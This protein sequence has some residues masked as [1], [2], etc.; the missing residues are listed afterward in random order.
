MTKKKLKFSIY[1]SIV[2]NRIKSIRLLQNK[3]LEEWGKIFGASKGN[4]LLWE[5]GKTLPNKKRLEKIAELGNTTINKLL[6]GNCE[7]FLDLNFIYYHILYN[8]PVIED[9]FLLVDIAS[10]I[11][12]KA[13]EAGYTVDELEKLGIFYKDNFEIVKNELTNGDKPLHQRLYEIV[14]RYASIIAKQ[15]DSTQLKNELVDEIIKTIDK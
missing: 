6:Y 14:D 1:S 10:K 12:Q 2:G 8:I 7:E 4:V 15:H 5:Q 13:E 3:T 9:P 11:G